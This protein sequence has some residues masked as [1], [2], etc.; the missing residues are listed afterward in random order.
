MDGSGEHCGKTD[1]FDP[2]LIDE[3]II[4]FHFSESLKVN[5]R[6]SKQVKKY[7]GSFLLPY[8]YY[9]YPG[10]IGLYRKIKSSIKSMTKN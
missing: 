10:I 3:N 8:L 4:D 5:H 1:T 9:K 2:V 7:Y 6:I